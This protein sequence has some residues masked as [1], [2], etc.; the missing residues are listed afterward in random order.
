M[1]TDFDVF[2][3]AVNGGKTVAGFGGNYGMEVFG[4]S[5]NVTKQT[6]SIQ[7]RSQQND[8]FN[9][10]K[11]CAQHGVLQTAIVVQEDPPIPAY[12]GIAVPPKAPPDNPEDATCPETV[13]DTLEGSIMEISCPFLTNDQIEGFSA[14]IYREVQLSTE[15]TESG[16]Y[17]FSRGGYGVFPGMLYNNQTI[18]TVEFTYGDLDSQT[19]TITTGPRFYQPGS[20]GSDS[21]YIKRSETLNKTGTVVRSNVSEGRF[22]VDIEGLGV[23]DAINGVVDSIHVGDKVEVKILNY[24]VER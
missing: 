14:K 24:P 4:M 12:N 13:L 21:T 10:A 16:S 11:H 9:I 6:A 1:S 23:Y 2:S 17:T 18:H 7:V 15:D 5:L 8:A 19:T 20:A 3:D 22:S